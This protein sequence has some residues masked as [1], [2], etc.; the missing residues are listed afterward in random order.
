MY[1]QSPWLKEAERVRRSIEDTIRFG[2]EM[3]GQINQWFPHLFEGPALDMRHT[4]RDVRI[5]LPLSLTSDGSPRMWA[6]R[7][8]DRD[9]YLNGWMDRRFLK[10]IPLPYPVKRTPK[11]IRFRNGALQLRLARN[12]GKADSRWFEFTVPPE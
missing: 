2:E 4:E 12:D 6:L 9:L 10:R 1:D 7:V 3:V 11:S 5:D 8:E